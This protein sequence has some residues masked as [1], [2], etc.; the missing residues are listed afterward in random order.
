MTKQE[1]N[2]QYYAKNA[3]KARLYSSN[4]RATHAEQVK[5]SKRKWEA[6][7]R[8]R[9][10]PIKQAWADNNREKCRASVRKHYYK[11][12]DKLNAYLRERRRT[13]VQYRVKKNIS[14]K[15]NLALHRNGTSKSIPTLG[16]IGC[17]LPFL[18]NFL[19]A[20]FT[21]GMSWTNYGKNGWEIDHVIPCKRFDLSKIDQQ[22]AC[23]HYSNLQPLWGLDNRLKSW[24]IP[25]EH[26]AELL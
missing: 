3:E 19:A 25:D 11:N 21:N 2:R 22:R 6:K 18:K 20:R 13:N 9:L 14:R 16:L 7:S 17:D 26:Q 5:E 8:E 15:I 4:Y 24:K 10:R 1:Y 23:F 12:R